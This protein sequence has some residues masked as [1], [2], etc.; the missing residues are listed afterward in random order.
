M[1]LSL[2]SGLDAVVVMRRFSFLG[3]SVDEYVGG[4][5]GVFVGVER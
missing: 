2:G 5:V 3:V 4:Y 1:S